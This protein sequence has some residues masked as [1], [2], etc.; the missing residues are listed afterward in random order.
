MTKEDVEDIIKLYNDINKSS[1]ELSKNF[2]PE[3]K[4]PDAEKQGVTLL[5]NSG[6]MSGLLLALSTG[7]WNIELGDYSRI[8]RAF[9]KGEGVSFEVIASD[10][11]NPQENPEETV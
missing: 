4:E 7:G 9:Y 1:E 5:Y 8:K 2:N 10:L 3:D 11:E 6:V